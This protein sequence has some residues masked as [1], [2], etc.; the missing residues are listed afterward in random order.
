MLALLVGAYVLL[1]IGSGLVLY[2]IYRA[3][4]Q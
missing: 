4:Q 2:G 3:D 1:A